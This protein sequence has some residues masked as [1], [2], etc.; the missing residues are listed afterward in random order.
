MAPRSTISLAH[1]PS[2]S[3]DIVG[4]PSQECAIDRAT[5]ARLSPYSELGHFDVY[6]P[7]VSPIDLFVRAQAGRQRRRVGGET[8]K[9]RERKGEEGELAVDYI[10][11]QF[12][13][14]SLRVL[15]TG[16]KVGA[17]ATAG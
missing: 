12:R 14:V 2:S 7:C 9:E 13:H 1:L 11:P 6:I 10:V 8:A 15:Y 3:A 4:F 5:V 16:H 17:D